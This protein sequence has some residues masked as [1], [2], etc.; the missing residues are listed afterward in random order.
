MMMKG[1]KKFI[2]TAKAAS[3]YHRIQASVAARSL[4]MGIHTTIMLTIVAGFMG[5]LP[6]SKIHYGWPGSYY[7][8]NSTDADTGTAQGASALQTT[9]P[10]N[11][12]YRRIEILRKP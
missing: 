5:K 8:E 10:L 2:V 11:M 7:V 3:I 6:L 12:L 4:Q 1:K 9:S